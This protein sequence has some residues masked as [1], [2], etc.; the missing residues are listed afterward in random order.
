[1]ANLVRYRALG[2]KEQALVAIGVLLDGHDAVEYLSSD[3]HRKTALSRAARDVA[4]LPAELRMPLI[5]TLL[6][7]AVARL[8]ESN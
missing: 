6:R 3:R 1:M 5:G 7:A 4:D 8:K 2:D